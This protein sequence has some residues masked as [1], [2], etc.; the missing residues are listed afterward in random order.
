M[1]DG[2]DGDDRDDG[3]ETERDPAL[4][5]DDR[6]LSPAF[7]IELVEP[8]V[9]GYV[10]HVTGADLLANVHWHGPENAHWHFAPLEVPD[11]GT[12]TARTRFVE[13]ESRE[14][15]P[16]GDAERFEQRVRLDDDSPGDVL[17]VDVDGPLVE[18]SGRSPGEVRLAFELRR[19]GET[20]W[21]SPS[22]RVEIVA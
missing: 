16:L 9:E 15:L 21:T 13:D 5:I 7:P 19:G 1:L 10:G 18:F 14:A 22:L 17:E 20:R 6:Y 12:R 4:R 11:A 3:V 2:D 8:D